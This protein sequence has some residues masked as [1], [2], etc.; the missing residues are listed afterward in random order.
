MTRGAVDLPPGE[1]ERQ[2][3]HQ[4]LDRR[5][6]LRVV[7]FLTGV[8]VHILWWDVF[9]RK[10][11]P[12][13]MAARSADRRWRHL[14]AR[15]RRLAV[16]LGGLQIKLGQFL[17]ARVDVLPRAVT[18]ELAGLQ[19]EVP[20][21]GFEVV[22]EVIEAAFGAPCDVVFESMDPVPVGA[23]SLA[24]AHRAR[25]PGGE[26]VIV[27][28]QRPRIGVLVETD[29]AAFH[30]GTRMLG[31]L[32]WVRRRADLEALSD[33][34][35]RTSRKE[36]DF[37]AEGRHAEAFAEQFAEDEDVLV[38][39]VHWSHTRERVLTLE[40]VTGI[41]ISDVQALQAAGVV[42]GDVARN[43][44]N[45][46]LRQIFVHNFVHVDPHPGNLF[47]HPRPARTARARGEGLPFRIAFVDFGMVAVVPERVRSHLRELIVGLATRDAG[48]IVRA[49]YDAGVL[50]PGADLVRIEQ[51]TATALD[52]FWGV[53]MGDFQELA[54]SE[55]GAMLAEFGDILREMPFQM[56]SDLLFIGRAAGMLSGLATEL[57]PDFNFWAEVTPF[58]KRLA[59]GEGEPPKW[60]ARLGPLEGPIETLALLAS[61]LEAPALSLLALPVGLQ[62]V[63]SDASTGQLT[64]RYEL[65]PEASRVARRQARALSGVSWAIVFAG[66]MIGGAILRAAEGPSTASSA[67]LVAAAIALVVAVLRR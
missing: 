50:L 14:A 59:A 2:V 17:S 38:P 15:Y 39:K 65:A 43:V 36:L 12:F 20:A 61:S 46:Y 48:R 27:K 13:D 5:R 58:A 34:F 7:L 8:F 30:Y 23:A 51:A 47:V 21:V 42:P 40:D 24:Q 62:R 49:Y 37:E 11:L 53:R 26:T 1:R 25:L 56:P 19:D 67:I 29:L 28:V 6:Y 41:K 35:A 63:L 44:V 32:K 4:P 60:T 16:D 55:A 10:V 33:E 66:L 52:R 31:R 64:L 54:A 3:E 18:S 57:D 9:L 45:N 22:R